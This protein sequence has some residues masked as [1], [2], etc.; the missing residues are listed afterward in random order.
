MNDQTLEDVIRTHVS[1]GKP[2]ATGWFPVLCAVCNDHGHKGPRAGF[3]FTE[4]GAAYKCFNCGHRASF[5]PK[6]HLDMPPGML[7]V[8]RSFG[9]SEDE[10]AP[11]L[12]TALALQDAGVSR[13]TATKSAFSPPV[14]QPL[15]AFFQRLSADDPTDVLAME[16][17]DYLSSRH[18]KWTDH[19]FY[20]ASRKSTHPDMKRWIGRLIIPIY[21]KGRLVFWQGRDFLGRQSQK[22]MSL[23]VKK[24]SVLGLA[25]NIRQ[26]RDR[27]LYVV[28]GWFDAFHLGGVAC[29]GSQL[30]AAQIEILNSTPR[31]KVIIPD[32][33]GDGHLLAMQAIEQ[34]WSISTPDIGS[35]KDVNE[36]IIR[37]GEMYTLQTIIDHTVDDTFAASVAVG[38]YCDPPSDIQSKRSKKRTSDGRSG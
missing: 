34:G 35:C 9:V 1:L 19:P 4:G 21:Y 7:T 33:Y 11:V 26:S 3:I 15:P 29:F 2:A 27:P 32:K 16:A 8:L 5:D 6:E 12:F 13:E 24:D 31:K 14:E 22:Y 18:I 20:L 28:E 36:A 25:D 37:Y 38:V 10:W 23:N 30:T 17:I